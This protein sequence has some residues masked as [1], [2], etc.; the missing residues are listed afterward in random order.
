[1]HHFAD[2]R[3]DRIDLLIHGLRQR[4]IAR[5]QPCFA[6]SFA[7]HTADPA[8]QHERQ[9]AAFRPRLRRQIADQFPIGRQALSS[10][11]LQTALRRKIGVSDDEAAVH[12]IVADRLDQKAL[13]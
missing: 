3:G 13:S 6:H 7:L 12:D 4:G 5:R 10:A 9:G 11:S 2:G 1:M 8:I